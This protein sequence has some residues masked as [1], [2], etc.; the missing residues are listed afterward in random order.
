MALLMLLH[1]IRVAAHGAAGGRSS[2]CAR[3]RSAR[4][5]SWRGRCTHARRDLSRSSGSSRTSSCASCRR[6][7]SCSTSTSACRSSTARSCSTTSSRITS[8]RRAFRR[9][10]TCAAPTRASRE[11]RRMVAA[12]GGRGYDLVMLCDHGMTPSVS[13]RVRFRETLGT[14]VQRILEGDAAA[15]ARCRFGRSRASPQTSE[16]ADVG[17]QVVETVG[18]RHAIP[19]QASALRSGACAIGC[20]AALRHSR[21]DAAREVSGRCESTA[22]S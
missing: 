18:G 2:G 15:P 14:T 7:R 13:Y 16:Y 6:W 4:A 3:S 12:A 21:A 1:P 11:I 17:A 5:A 8:G 9:C 19:S 20:A 22:S 10:A